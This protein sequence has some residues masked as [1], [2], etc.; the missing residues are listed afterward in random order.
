MKK[1]MEEAL[2]I[3][4]RGKGKVEPNPMVGAA[5]VKDGKIIAK[6]HHEKFGG[7]HAEITAL[8]K[9]GKK[10]RGAELY[11]NLE[12]C[13]H[14]G[15][16]PPCTR[17]IIKAGIKKVYMAMLDP[18]HN[19]KKGKEA[20]QKAGIEVETGILEKKAKKLN[21]LY[22]TTVGLQ[23]KPLITLK[24]AM[25]GNGSIAWGTGKRKKI[26]GKEA[27]KFTQGLREW[28]D[29]VLTG[30]NTI[31]RDNP[32]LSVRK[33]PSKN[34]VRII[35]DTWARTPINAGAFSQKGGTIVVC[36]KTAPKKRIEALR[37]KA[38]VILAKE[39]NGRIDMKWLFQ[40]LEAIG[41]ESMLVEAGSRINSEI[42][43]KGLFDKIYF[44]VADFEK[45]GLPAFRLK[46]RVTLKLVSQKKLGKDTLIQVVH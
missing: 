16:Q 42:I 9:A 36:S 13:N 31:I 12:P 6:G 5:I 22:I 29:G 33:K 21:N 38:E 3:A 1:F 19:S 45:K 27:F 18:N 15:K 23:K 20:L 43:S 39:L 30:V 35:L 37:E 41:I 10:A 17:A 34:P 4:A 40:K 11:V 32:R 25:T 8:K 7:P 2:K 24:I 46:N 28:H 26:T 14:Y 44:I